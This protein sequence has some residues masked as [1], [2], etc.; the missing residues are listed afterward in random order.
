VTASE[1]A[2]SRVWRRRSRNSIALL[3]S[4]GLTVF[5]L[6]LALS[7]TVGLIASSSLA[8]IRHDLDTLPVSDSS[9]TLTAPLAGDAKAQDAGVRAVIA[10]TFDGVPLIVSRALAPTKPGSTRRVGWTIRPSPTRTTAADLAALHAGFTRIETAVTNSKAAR[11]SAAE[12]S[13]SGAATSLTM[14]RAEGALGAIEPIPLTVLS[15]AGIVALMLARGLLTDSRQNETRFLRSRGGSTNTLT[16]LD[17]RESIITCLIGALAG[18]VVAQAVLLGIVGPPVGV[19]QVVVPPLAAAAVAI[20]IN[21]V[22]SRAAAR[23]ASGTPRFESGRRRAAAPL[24]LT[25]FGIVVTGI[26][27][28]RFEQNGSDGATFAADPSAVIAPGALLC[29]GI[30]LGLIA[31]GRV[32]AGIEAGL[33]G[34]RGT[35]I[36]PIRSVNRHLALVAGPTALLALAIAIAAVS[37]SYIGSLQRFATDSQR[38]I[39]GGDVRTSFSRDPFVGGASDRV[40]IDSLRRVRGVRSAAIA[41]TQADTFGDVPVTVV[42]ADRAAL[43]GLVSSDS[44]VIAP[45]ALARELATSAPGSLALPAGA[46]AVDVSLSATGDSPTTGTHDSALVTLWIGNSRGELFPENLATIPVTPES[47]SPLVRVGALPA[48]TDAWSLEAIDVAITGP[49]TVRDF[50]FRVNSVEAVV[51][52]QRRTVDI[53]DATNWVPKAGVFDAGASTASAAGSIG[54][55]RSAIVGNQIPGVAVRIMPA[56]ETRAPVVLGATF[57][58]AAGLVIGSRIAVDGQTASFDGT[59]TGIVPS[60]PGAA[61]GDSLIASLPALQRSWLA[62]SEQIPNANEIWASSTTPG[63]TA[64]RIAAQIAGARVVVAGSDSGADIIRSADAAL[65]IGA[66]GTAAFAIIALIAAALALLRRRDVETSALRALG[67]APGVQSRLRRSEL[68]I[69][70]VTALVVGAIIGGAVSL[71]VIPTMA[72]LATPTAPTNLP[73]LIELDPTPLTLTDALLV[74]ALVV[75]AVVYGGAV[76]RRAEGRRR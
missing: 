19:A 11:S 61:N 4:I 13:G 23:S 65:W 1:F 3:T 28:W 33:R 36:L 46:T 45:A 48:S 42:G 30:L 21:V 8:S 60:V 26:A 24:T 76:R 10:K 59:V 66:L 38:L 5:V 51:E 73:L 49:Q 25:G 12:S 15:L 32:T 16:S 52:G 68:A 72:R 63:P 18:A 74:I 17:A 53:P 29:V 31:A 41:A 22:L 47:V 39:T 34:S 67:V 7:A 6:S 20:A 40:P 27:V 9:V 62:T 57:A 71:I 54:F 2:G 55:D 64:E 44:T 58:A 43:A 70:A 56:G 14:V 35:T 69:V 75:C 50:R 37:G